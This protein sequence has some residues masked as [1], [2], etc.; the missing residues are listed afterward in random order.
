MKQL[1]AN[2]LGCIK[3]ENKY[4]FRV[5]SPTS[6]NIN[7]CIYN[8]AEDKHKEIYSMLKDENSVWSVEIESDLNEKYYTYEVTN[9]DKLVESVD[10]YSKAVSINGGKTAI[11][12]LEKTNPDGFENYSGYK[13]E[14]PVDAVIYEVHLRDISIDN[15]SEIKHKGKFLGLA[16][17][18]GK[19]GLDYIKDLGVTHIQLLPIYDFNSIDEVNFNSESENEN[20]NNY[21]WGYDPANYNVPEGSYSTNP[22]CPT[23]RIKELKTLINS[24]H[25]KGLGVIMDVVYNHMYDVENSSFNKLVPKYYFRYDN[26]GN[27]IN[28]SGCGNAIASENKMVRKYIVDS[29][30]YWAEEYK[31]DGFRFDLMGLLDV[32]TMNEIREELNKINPSIIII[33]EGW[34]MGSTLR[35]EDKAI[36]LNA[37]KLKGIGV[38]NDIIRDGLRGNAFIENDTGFV[39]GN[40]KKLNDVKKGI[41]GGINYNEYINSWGEINPSQVVNYVECHDNHT[42]YDKLKIT[43][44][45]EEQ[46]K[47]MHRLGTS[48]IILSQGIPFIHAGQEFL[49]TKQGIENSY[50][51]QDSINKVDWNRAKQNQDSVDYIK[52]LIS[53][54]K[55]YPE[56]RLQSVKEIKEKIEFINLPEGMVG[57]K[58]KGENNELVVIHNA[59][60]DRVKINLN[61]TWDVLVNKNQAGTKT[62]TTIENEI[63]LENLSTTVLCLK[64]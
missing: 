25:N 12:D 52:G 58:I 19:T 23:T 51:A 48:I 29:V 43:V 18:N 26:N 5:W 33:G 6:Y 35:V 22:Y 42:F 54:R 47:Y 44:K 64:K 20:S 28:E 2:D 38:F 59:K 57:Y 46:L 63:L 11:V 39:A 7:L 62:I 9:G 15:N 32:K 61:G 41:V 17:E 53:L 60:Q 24:I 8:H 49:R 36:Q 27:L 10:P 45:N 13:I 16:E 31:I 40:F 3:I 50:N 21:N 37:H 4:I 1:N 55:K 14:N 34:N 56:F 30:K